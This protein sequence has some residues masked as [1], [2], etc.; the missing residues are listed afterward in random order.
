LA[1]GGA[2]S[3]VIRQ[4]LPIGGWR[5]YLLP[6][7]PIGRRPQSSSDLRNANTRPAA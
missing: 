5:N 2:L 4:S 6:F 7:P 1:A 3:A